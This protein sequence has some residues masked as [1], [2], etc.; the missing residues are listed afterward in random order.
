METQPV[1][2]IFWIIITLSCIA[3]YLLPTI[4]AA[5]GRHPHAMLIAALN[6]LLG[7][8]IL[9]WGALL[10]W[11]MDTEYISRITTAGRGDQRAQLP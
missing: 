1:E 6:L 9:V 5:R 3:G 8:T 11:A 2:L 10:L 4:V 7:W